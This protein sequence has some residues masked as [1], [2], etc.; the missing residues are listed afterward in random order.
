MVYYNNCVI[1]SI[2]YIFGKV[3]LTNSHYIDNDIIVFID[4]IMN[5]NYFS[6]I[7]IC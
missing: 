7:V 2:T 5:V 4:S 1:L 6:F 3:Y